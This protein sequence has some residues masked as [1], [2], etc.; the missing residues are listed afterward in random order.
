MDIETAKKYDRINE[1]VML[2]NYYR[3]IYYNEARSEISDYEY[4]NL[5][6]E[7]VQL[8]K[9]TGH[10]LKNSPTQ[11]VGYVVKSSLQKV[12]HN[13]EMLSLDKTKDVKEVCKFINGQKAV[14][15]AKMDGLT[16]SL[17][18]VNGILVSAET[19]GD[20]FIG[21]DVLHNINVMESVPKKIF[22]FQED[23]VIDGEVIATYRDFNAINNGLAEDVQYKHIRNYASGSVRLLDS[24]ESEKR[25]LKFVAWKLV[26]GSNNDSFIE[27]WRELLNYGFTVVP[28]VTIPRYISEETVTNAINTIKEWAKKEDY[29][30]DGCVIGF[31]S[32]SYGQSLGK[33]A[34]HFKDQIAF[35]FYDETYPT[36]LKYIDWTMGKT[37]VLTP[38]AVFNPVN[39]D[40][41][42]IERASLHNISIIKTL[43]LTN[44]CSVYIYKANQIIPQ[45][46]SCDPDGDGDIEYPTTC[47]V[48]GGR[49]LIKRDNDSEVLTCSNPNCKGKLL[50]KF[51]N[52]VGR[53]ATNIVGL[54]EATID[55]FINWGWIS[56][57]KDLYHLDKY[58]DKLSE[59]DGYGKKSV[60][61]LLEALETSK[62]IKLENYI[63]AIGINGIG[64]QNAKTISDYFE[65][66]YDK[67]INA[68]N[69][70]FD[71][72]ALDG[73]GETMD[74]AIKEW[75]KNDTLCEGLAEEFN[76]IKEEKSTD[77]PL[78][79]L[80]FCITGTFSENRDT[81]KEQLINK[82][83]I[84]VSGVSSKLDVLFAGENAGSKLTKAQE[85]GI[86]I[87][88]EKELFENY[89][90]NSEQGIDKSIDLW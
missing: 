33:T 84:F 29:P 23:V 53:K 14:V 19:R 55:D 24:K 41:T 57:F 77:T 11:T 16:C 42:T 48:C 73:F 60:T 40:G 17:H 74:R 70:G 28:I 88:G 4:D 5:Y 21:E 20:G 6:D 3:D 51:I 35:K 90:K 31:D 25:K 38:T 63:N 1:L 82:G 45:V 27:R 10:I 9:E 54:S 66:D 86:K 13:H 15:M 68:L 76:F 36:K 71:F 59:V 64:L 72:T 62:T 30:I 67:F 49:T 89:L 8:E 39:I 69:N 56:K 50:A 32:V 2:L 58:A 52:F 75:Y 34:H 80:R 43:G 7:L 78:Q 83:A 79:G 22:T 26:S 37:G 85:L 47:P 46:D 61:K 12:K 81:I 44:H 87:V 65:G 18:Y